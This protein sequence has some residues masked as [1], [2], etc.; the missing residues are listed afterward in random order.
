MRTPQAGF[1][2]I[3]LLV[4]LAISTL[5]LVG[6]LAL[7]KTLTRGVATT[8]QT[9]EALSFGSR[10]LESLR[11]MRV[12]QM[13]ASIEPT[14]SAP[15]FGQT[16]YATS[17]GRTGTSYQADV[18]VT[19]VPGTAGLWRLRIEVSWTEGDESRRIPLEV[20]RTMRDSL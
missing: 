11:A 7:H 3:E 20:L 2:M 14:A 1:T 6:V 16:A 19:E 10:T 5:G 12:D 17:T 9:Q 13:I 4:T 18:Q 15:P 8:E